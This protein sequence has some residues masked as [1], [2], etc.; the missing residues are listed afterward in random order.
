MRSLEFT[1]RFEVHR[2]T[3]KVRMLYNRISELKEMTHQKLFSE[4]SNLILNLFDLAKC[5]EIDERAEFN[6]VI[7]GQRDKM[8]KLLTDSNGSVSKKY[9]E[10]FTLYNQIVVFDL[11]FQK[12]DSVQ[13]V[14]KSRIDGIATPDY[15]KLCS[16]GKIANLELKTLSFKG[17]EINFQN[18][19]RDIELTDEANPHWIYK[20]AFA[21]TSNERKANTRRD[22]IE[23]I[24]GRVTKHY[25]K[26]AKGQ[27]R[28]M[29][30]PGILLID[31]TLL[32]ETLLFFLQ[33]AL[34]GFVLDCYTSGCL[35]NAVFGRIDDVIYQCTRQSANIEHDP[36]PKGGQPLRR[37]GILIEAQSPAAVIFITRISGNKELKKIIGFS[38]SLLSQPEVKECLDV[39]CDY[40]NDENNSNRDNLRIV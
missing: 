18:I 27:I 14:A 17:S 7:Y 4:S 12:D 8:L 13:F 24:S 6:C 32:E 35:W 19:Q 38:N 16:S 33:D 21:S 22:V 25:Q 23:Q 34:P 28:F 5:K 20:S 37:N 39:F 10:C 30:R 40:Q 3:N 11:L 9:E 29:G 31:T 1:N 36:L 15:S 2:E 26:S